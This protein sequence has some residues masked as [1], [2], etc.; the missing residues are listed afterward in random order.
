MLDVPYYKLNQPNKRKHVYIGQSTNIKYQCYNFHPLLLLF[1]S[2]FSHQKE[3][4][5]IT[6]NYCIKQYENWKGHSPFCI[7][8]QLLKKMYLLNI[9]VIISIYYCFASTK[10]IEKIVQVGPECQTILHCCFPATFLRDLKSLYIQ[11]HA[12]TKSIDSF[13]TI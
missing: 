5:F 13:F 6:P 2:F 1:S 9:K 12:H 4:T 11:A 3:R 8:D 7:Y 10:C